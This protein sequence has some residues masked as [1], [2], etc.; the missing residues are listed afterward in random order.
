MRMFFS[1]K[2]VYKFR[3]PVELSTR[4]F[5]PFNSEENVT[6]TRP[7]K[8]WKIPEEAAGIIIGDNKWRRMIENIMLSFALDVRFLFHSI[9][10]FLKISSRSHQIIMTN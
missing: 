6:T 3:R 7:M 4:L 10:L 8:H 9:S 5:S 1:S 2:L